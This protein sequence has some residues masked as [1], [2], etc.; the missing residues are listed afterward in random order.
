MQGRKHQLFYLES[1]GDNRNQAQEDLTLSKM[2]LSECCGAEITLGCCDDCGYQTDGEHVCP[3]CGC[4][5]VK[6]IDYCEDCEEESS[7]WA[8][9]DEAISNGRMAIV[10]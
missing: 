7:H 8:G 2:Y 4:D 1:T 3:D 5:V 6:G 9:V 10:T